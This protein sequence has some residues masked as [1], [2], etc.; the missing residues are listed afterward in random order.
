MP[1]LLIVIAILIWSSLGVFV[2]VLDLE[3]QYI[4]FYSTLFSLPIQGVIILSSELKY[5]V[6]PL[7]DFLFIVLLSICLLLNTF[8][9][10][11]AYKK[12]TIAN[13][14]L[15]HYI[16]PVLVA[17]LGAMFLGE[18]VTFRVVAAIV[19]A[20]V[21][22]W[23]M[24]GG[25]T[26]GEC[27]RGVFV[28]GFSI[29]DDLIGITSGLASGLFYAVLIILIRVFAQKFNPY[30][31]VF[32]QNMFVVLFLL[33]FVS[34]VTMEKILILLIMGIFHSTLAP[35]LYYFGL[36]RVQAQRAAI[37]GYLEPVGAIIFSMLFLAE[38]PGLRSYIGG[39][40]VLLS[41]YI[42]LTENR[43]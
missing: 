43:K 20:T 10:L 39:L 33:P 40:L 3:V 37:L 18:K 19:I 13:A 25:A 21:G 30:V 26:I 31:L 2:R 14:V 27:I 7:R 34:L 38:I 12:T 36:S 8:T 23:I 29:T 22:L 11:F 16:A 5:K 6:P 17:F 28:E 15:T 41:G 24:L 9:F 32:F 4:L 35:Y 1:S 42:T